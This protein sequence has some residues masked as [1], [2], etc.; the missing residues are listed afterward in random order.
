MSSAVWMRW[1]RSLRDMQ[2]VLD[3]TGMTRPVSNQPVA[4]GTGG[5]YPATRTCRCR[6]HTGRGGDT[7]KCERQITPSCL[8]VAMR[9]AE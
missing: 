2:F 4:R 5:A 9:F 8:S 1:R 6:S 7:R 3:H